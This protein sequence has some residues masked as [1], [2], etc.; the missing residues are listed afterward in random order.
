[1]FI[2]GSSDLYLV[3]SSFTN[4]QALGLSSVPPADHFLSTA[5]YETTA[6]TMAAYTIEDE[7]GRN[8]DGEGGQDS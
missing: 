4:N 6:A 8:L 2:A 5:G 3:N 1:M 7:V